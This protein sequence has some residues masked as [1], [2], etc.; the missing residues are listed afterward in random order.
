MTAEGQRA[1]ATIRE[2]IESDHFSLSVHFR[3]RMDQRGLFWPDLQAIIEDPQDIQLR[4]DW[5][6]PMAT[7][8]VGLIALGEHGVGDRMEATGPNVVDRAVVAKTFDIDLAR[9]PPPPDTIHI[10]RSSSAINIDGVASE[11]G[12]LGA[13]WSPEFQQAEGCGESLGK[14]TAKMIWDDT[15][16][17]LFVSITD[18]DI[19][20]EFTKHDESL[21]KADDVEIFIDADSNKRTYVELQVNPNNATFDS[22]FVD[23]AHPDPTWDSHMVT[24]VQ[25]KV[26]HQPQGDVTTGW[27]VEVGIPWEDVKGREVEMAVDLPP[28]IGQRW[29]LN[30]VRVDK[31]TNGNTAWASS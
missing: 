13:P 17:Y 6:S 31:Q 15:Y 14:A 1:I 26:V 30:V 7:L 10:R 3:E 9:A 12:W 22:W 5:K 28:K 23:R 29:R 27:D 21:W 8:Q 16:L 20:S 25:K 18:P 2:C 24:A 11:P 19:L 4:P